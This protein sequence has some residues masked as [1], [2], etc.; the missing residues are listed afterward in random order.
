M[1]QQ[2]LFTFVILCEA[3][4]L[5]VASLRSSTCNNLSGG[6]SMAFEQPLELVTIADSKKP[7]SCARVLECSVFS[8]PPEGTIFWYKNNKVVHASVVRDITLNS[9]AH[10]SSPLHGM[11]TLRHRLCVDSL[12]LTK[13]AEFKCRAQS[14]CNPL[15]S[16]ESLPVEVKPVV[17]ASLGYANRYYKAPLITLVS[18]TRIEAPGHFVQLFCSAEGMPKPE[19]SWRILDNKD[20]TTS[21]PIEDARFIWPIG[22]GNLIIDTA[23]TDA[24]TLSFQCIAENKFGRDVAD[25]TLILMD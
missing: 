7:S 8:A 2:L 15:E 22:N 19:L 17:G 12:V 24:A 11:T 16:I 5:L 13:S 9:A 3:A 10:V 18:S 23:K 14:P 25:S 4:V 6:A 21:Y 20:E 1:A